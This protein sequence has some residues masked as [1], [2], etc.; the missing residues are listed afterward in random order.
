M[1]KRSDNRFTLG[2]ESFAQVSAVESIRLSP[3]A[4]KRARDFDRHDLSPEQRRQQIL[5]A[6]RTKG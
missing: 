2:R 4:E 3:Q 6:H 5:D 1:E